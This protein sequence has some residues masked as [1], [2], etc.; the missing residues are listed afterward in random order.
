MSAKGNYDGAD[1]FPS[2]EA[3]EVLEE[4]NPPLVTPSHIRLCSSLKESREGRQE[5]AVCVSS[6]PH[7]SLMGR[8]RIKDDVIP[9]RQ[10]GI[11]MGKVPTYKTYT[12]LMMPAFHPSS[13]LS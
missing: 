2:C 3:T 8:M 13:P 4:R 10:Q 1:M 9:S 12:S 6:I 7:R 11:E 5:R